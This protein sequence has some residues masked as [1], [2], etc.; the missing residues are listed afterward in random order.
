VQDCKIGDK[1]VLITTTMPYATSLHTPYNVVKTAVR[2]GSTPTVVRHVATVAA[3]NV[4]TGSLVLSST[5]VSERTLHG[6][7]SGSIGAR[8][9][10][11]LLD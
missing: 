4:A 5:D 2:R 9:R 11:S 8:K 7:G 3:M 6:D 1:L 10:R